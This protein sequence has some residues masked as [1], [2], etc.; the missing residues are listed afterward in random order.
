MSP[1]FAT[2]TPS[3]LREP[4]TPYPGQAPPSAT[5]LHRTLLNDASSQELENAAAAADVP[6][7]KE[8]VAKDAP[9]PKEEV[10][11]TAPQHKEEVADA[12]P[13]QKRQS[14]CY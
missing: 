5:V 4:Q 12:D 14:G 7:P 8:D 10:V 1:F 2:N 6:T 9:Q 13:Q 3:L 11:D